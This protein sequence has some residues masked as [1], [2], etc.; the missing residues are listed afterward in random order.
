MFHVKQSIQILRTVQIFRFLF[1]VKQKPY[2]TFTTRKT[3]SNLLNKPTF[4][5]SHTKQKPSL[6]ISVFQTNN[7][8]AATSHKLFHVKQ[9]NNTHYSNKILSVLI[10]KHNIRSLPFVIKNKISTLYIFVSRETGVIHSV[11]KMCI[12]FV[13]KT[14]KPAVYVRPASCLM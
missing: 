11:N 6:P 7:P 1:H 13:V 10:K 12:T 5:I 4:P 2:K 9:N 8:F 3:R 14:K